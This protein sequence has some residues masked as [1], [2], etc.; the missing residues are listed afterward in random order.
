MSIA[1]SLN[2]N[3]DEQSRALTSVFTTRRHKNKTFAMISPYLHDVLR[4]AE[5]SREKHELLWLEISRI[6]ITLYN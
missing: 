3:Y 4:R 2:I 6:K 5:Y 1:I